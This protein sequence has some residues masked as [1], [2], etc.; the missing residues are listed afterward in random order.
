M[1][2]ELL[3]FGGLV[4]ATVVAGVVLRV[5]SVG[6]NKRITITTFDLGWDLFIASAAVIPTALIVTSRPIGSKQGLAALIVVVAILLWSKGEERYFA[7]WREGKKRPVLENGDLGE[8][9]KVS[10]Q[11]AKLRK[12]AAFLLG[13]GLGLAVLFA[14]TALSESFGK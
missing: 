4:G 6:N 12:T 1:A 8:P 10:K 11:S 2:H 9:V 13:N 5:N 3:L 7:V 14:A